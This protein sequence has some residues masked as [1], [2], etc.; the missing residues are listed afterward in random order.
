MQQIQFTDL[1]KSALHVSGDKLAHPQE[2]F[3]TVC[4]VK[5]C[6][7]GWASLSPETCRN[8]LERSVNVICCIL[9]AAY[10]VR[11]TWIRFPVGRGKC[12]VL[13]RVQELAP[14]CILLNDYDGLL[15]GLSETSHFHLERRLKFVNLHGQFSKKMKV[16]NGLASWPAGCICNC[17]SQGFCYVLIAILWALNLFVILWIVALIVRC[18]I[19]LSVFGVIKMGYSPGTSAFSFTVLSAPFS[20]APLC[21][22]HLTARYTSRHEVEWVEDTVNISVIRITYLLTYLLTHLLHR[23]QSFLRC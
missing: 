6:S 3:L 23:T 20:D 2:H 13:Q 18:C 12:S 7:W 17:V 10:V 8:D 1:S 21:V 15:L 16:C 9:L 5:K 19:A 11:L 22:Q 14:S 4:T